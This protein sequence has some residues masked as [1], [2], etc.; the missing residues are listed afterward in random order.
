[1]IAAWI[2]DSWTEL[3]VWGMIA[4]VTALF[5]I[6]LSCHVLLVRRRALVRSAVWNAVCIADDACL[7]AWS[8]ADPVRVPPCRSLID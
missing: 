1:M 6:G 8:S 7:L 5:L 3:F 2:I 4:R